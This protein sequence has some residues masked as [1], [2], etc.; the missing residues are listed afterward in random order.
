MLD[1]K[2]NVT[3]SVRC[4]HRR[5]RRAALASVGAAVVGSLLWTYQASIEPYRSVDISVFR[6]A[7][8]P[9]IICVFAALALRIK[10][11]AIRGT[12]I[13]SVLAG[14]PDGLS[15]MKTN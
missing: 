15:L 8:F 1:E 4:D 6:A 3:F 9:I 10:N 12:V 5:S 13:W 2:N 14:K 7:A 11:D